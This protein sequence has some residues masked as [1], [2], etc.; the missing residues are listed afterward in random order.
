M[1]ECASGIYKYKVI[2]NTYINTQSSRKKIEMGLNILSFGKKGSL[3]KKYVSKYS[4]MCKCN[5]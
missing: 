2:S 5:V 1:C 4:R 3:N